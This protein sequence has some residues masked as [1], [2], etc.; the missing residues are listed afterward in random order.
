MPLAGQRALCCQIALHGSRE[1]ATD[2]ETQTRPLAIELLAHLD[3]GLEHR[4][5]AM[6]VALDRDMAPGWC[7]FDGV[8]HQVEQD[9]PQLVETDDV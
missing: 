1:L 2:R 4:K 8:R 9:L 7:E 3:E 6:R 5:R